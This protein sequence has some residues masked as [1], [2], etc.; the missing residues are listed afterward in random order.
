[1]KVNLLT[2]IKQTLQEF[3]RN[4]MTR[5]DA[6]LAYY[7]FASFFPLLLIFVASVGLAL[8]YQLGMA[9]DAHRYVIET[10]SSELPPA[11][12]LL[13]QNMHDMQ[14][15]RGILGLVG[16]LTGI[17]AAS[18]IFVL[19]ENAFNVIFDAVPAQ[20]N[21]KTN[22]KSRLRAIL[23]V[24]LLAL[25]MGGSLI[26][27]SA[28]SMLPS[29][30]YDLPGGHFLAWLLNLAISLSLTT[31]VFAALFKYIPNKVVTW[32]AA[33]IGGIFSSLAWQ[34]GRELLTWWLGN[35]TGMTVSAVVGSVFGVLAL[36]YYGSQILM[37]GA[38]LTATYDKLV[39]QG[40][41]AVK[42]GLVEN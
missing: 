28:L 12:A 21:F 33:L 24:L 32:K 37:L 34:V 6:A 16:L 1:M 15:N 41:E 39:H 42:L 7:V 19:L 18:N 25:L 10:V 31:F 8:N 13:E 17:W 2:L 29:F 20:M 5:L 27:G 22:L 26:F 14:Q 3:A 11:M 35:Q 38:Q 36:I 4:N 23:I 30:G 40:V 9:Q